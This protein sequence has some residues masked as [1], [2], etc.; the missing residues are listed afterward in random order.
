MYSR[1]CA[2]ALFAISG[3]V[4]FV[5]Q[6]PC[7]NLPCKDNGKCVTIYETNRYVCICKKEFAG[8][9]C[10][11]GKDLEKTTIVVLMSVAVVTVPAGEGAA[12]AAVV[13]K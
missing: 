3:H 1:A 10:E 8:K 6:S 9:H 5:L 13:V 11:L 7:S 2:V 12:A 4:I